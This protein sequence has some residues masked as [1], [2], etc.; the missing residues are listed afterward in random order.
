MKLLYTLI[1]TVAIPTLAFSQQRPDLDIMLTNYEYPFEVNFLNIDSQ[2]QN[3]KMA[4]MDV[5]P[6][7]ANGKTV[8]L[9][10]GK[11]FNGAYWK[12]PLKHSQKKDTG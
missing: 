2:N 7:K 3:L 6:K 8:V 1:F 4:Y 5:H 9:L 12:Q 11:N 10:H